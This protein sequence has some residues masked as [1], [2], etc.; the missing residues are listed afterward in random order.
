MH[1]K[2]AMSIEIGNESYFIEIC[3]T[4]LRCP[5]LLQINY[6]IYKKKKKKLYENV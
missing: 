4:S 1:E 2:I 3:Y 5:S 6:W